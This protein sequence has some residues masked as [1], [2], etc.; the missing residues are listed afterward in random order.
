MKRL[1]LINFDQ[2]PDDIYIG[3]EP[4]VFN[5]SVH[6][7]GILVI[8]WRVDGY[9]DVY[10]QPELKI[11]PATYEI[12]GKGLADLIERPLE[13]ASFIVTKSGV[14]T[15]FTFEDKLGRSIEVT[16]KEENQKEPKPFGLLAPMG[17]VVEKPTSLPLVILHDFYFVRCANTKLS[18][19]INGRTHKPGKLPIPID[20]SRMYYLRYSPDPLILKFNPAHNGIIKPLKLI[21]KLEASLG[22]LSFDLI[23]NDGRSEI[24]TMRIH[25]E[26][27]V[28]RVEYSP[29]IPNLINM[30]SGIAV[31]GIF[32]IQGEPSTGIIKG[33]YKLERKGDLISIE[34]SPNKGWQ[35]NEKK[36]AVKL[37]YFL[38]AVFKNWPKTY[39]WQATIDV[40]DINN[41][42]MTSH[43]QRTGK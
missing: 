28:V 2:D 34:L 16:V 6:G 35:P 20:F 15:F 19:K 13:N 30:K 10:Y 14:D 12:T 23:D 24:I 17:S 33:E 42:I 32:A 18:I 7:E 11:D 40:S 36:L 31:N 41:V 22:N 43:W 26:G 38:G 1:L 3:F 27:H 5:D 4:Q 29:P 8:A 25:S 37:I 9:V 21:G 39:K